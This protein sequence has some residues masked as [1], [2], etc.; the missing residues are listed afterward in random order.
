MEFLCHSLGVN[1]FLGY[2]LDFKIHL[3][4]ILESLFVYI[5]MILF[6]CCLMKETGY[7]VFTVENSS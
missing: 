2:V 6:L 4:V 7:M 1:Q 5:F 3:I